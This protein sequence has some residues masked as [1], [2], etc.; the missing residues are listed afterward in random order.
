VHMSQG[1]CS[2]CHDQRFCSKCHHGLTMP[3]PSGWLQIHG[4]IA[5]RRGAAICADCHTKKDPKFCIRCHGLPMPHPAG[6][7]TTHPATATSKPALCAK[8]HGQDS[9]LR[10]HGLSLPHSASFIGSHWVEAAR[11]GSVCVKCHGNTS[12]GTTGDA[13]CYG[14]DCHAPTPSGTLPTSP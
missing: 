11:R 3:H 13:S 8:C 4:P 5:A 2:G 10:C 1:D 14:G 12:G 7:L 9:C 6:W